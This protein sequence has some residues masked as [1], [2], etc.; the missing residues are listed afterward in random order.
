MSDLLLGQ[1]V[2]ISCC[3]GR[4]F[5]RGKRRELCL[6]GLGQRTLVVCALLRF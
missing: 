4:M 1:E 6:R 5:T 2:F 3:Q